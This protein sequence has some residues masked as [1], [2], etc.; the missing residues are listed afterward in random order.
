MKKLWLKISQIKVVN[1][2]PGTRGNLTPILKG[3]LRVLPKW[4]WGRNSE[5]RE[6]SQQERQMYNED[7]RKEL[8]HTTKENHQTIKGETKS[9]NKQKKEL[10]KQ[11]ESKD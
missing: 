6:K 1:R 8:K 3:M 9:R 7:W 2:Y 10:Q 11:L 5:E 4:K